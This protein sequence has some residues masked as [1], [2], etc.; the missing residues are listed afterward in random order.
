M[1]AFANRQRQAEVLKH[2]AEID[3]AVLSLKTN[4]TFFLVLITIYS[5]AFYL[6]SDILAVLFS[7]FKNLAPV[8]T[9]IINFVKIRKL[10][11]NV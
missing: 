4:L 3:S 6:S 7:L 11:V 8:L 5:L 2:Q 10:F 1:Q 9:S